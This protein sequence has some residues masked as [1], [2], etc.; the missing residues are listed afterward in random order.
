M[1][2]EFFFY[3]TVATTDDS[4]IAMK[5]KKL[6]FKTPVN[7]EQAA[8]AILDPALGKSKYFFCGIKIEQLKK[9]RFMP[10]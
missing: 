6:W 2:N 1:I 5:V 8:Q 4:P 7:E 10:R 9:F 3:F